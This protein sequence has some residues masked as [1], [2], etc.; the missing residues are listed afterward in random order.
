MSKTKK[1]Q[2][3]KLVKFKKKLYMRHKKLQFTCAYQELQNQ[4]KANL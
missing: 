2:A 3:L 1:L 4:D